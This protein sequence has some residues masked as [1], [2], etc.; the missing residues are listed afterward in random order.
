MDARILAKMRT[1][2]GFTDF[3]SDMQV[4][5]PQVMVDIDRDRALT[6]GVTPQQIQD[7]LY[8]RLRQSPGVHH[9]HAFQ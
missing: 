8:T 4:A 7:A 9:L 6:L 1:L 2:A 3:N 5:A